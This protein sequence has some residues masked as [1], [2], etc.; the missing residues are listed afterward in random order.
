MDGEFLA[1][2]PGV[3]HDGGL[4][5]VHDL[6]D[7][8]EFAEAVVAVFLGEGFEDRGVFISHVLDVAEPIIYEPKSAVQQRGEHSAAAVV[9]DDDDVFYFQ[10]IHGELHD[11]ETI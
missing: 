9:A 1:A 10:H 3:L 2:L 11:R 7:D 5:D 6:F 4:G 8:V